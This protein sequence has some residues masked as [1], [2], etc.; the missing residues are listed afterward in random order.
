MKALSYL[1]PQRHLATLS[2]DANA[3]NISNTHTRI[4]SAT[5]AQ[6]EQ[7]AENNY[8]QDTQPPATS[9][10]SILYRYYKRHLS[11]ILDVSYT[12]GSLDPCLT[13]NASLLLYAL[14]LN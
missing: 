12:S 5:A 9:S 7:L 2:Q 8:K 10:L 1:N 3:I 13:F 11:K 4:H 6:S 14:Y